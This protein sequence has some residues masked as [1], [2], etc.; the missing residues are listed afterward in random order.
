MTS[1]AGKENDLLIL[2]C[3]E[4]SHDFQYNCVE[5]EHACVK[6]GV[7]FSRYDL[8]WSRRFG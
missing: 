2:S 7:P 6:C 1:K 8:A 5:R 3:T 4:G